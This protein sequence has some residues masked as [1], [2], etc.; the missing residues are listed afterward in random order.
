MFSVAAGSSGTGSGA[1]AA[2]WSRRGRRRGLGRRW[3]GRYGRGRSRGGSRLAGRVALRVGA[4][5]RAAVRAGVRGRG[6]PFGRRGRLGRRRGGRGGRRRRGRRDRRRLGNRRLADRRRRGT[7]GRLR[8]GGTD[9]S[10]AGAS[11]AISG[12][13]RGNGREEQQGRPGMRNSFLFHHER[14]MVS[15]AK[16]AGASQ[17]LR[18]AVRWRR[19]SDDRSMEPTRKVTPTLR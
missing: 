10:E 15:A 12:A 1:G 16:R 2:A 14:T 17:I 13:G 6:P 4:G 8:T 7:I 9:T 3:G 18:S 5:A 11:C 19:P